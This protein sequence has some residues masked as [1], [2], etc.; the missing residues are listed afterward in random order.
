MSSPEKHTIAQSEDPI[1]AQFMTKEMFKAIR[2]QETVDI[3]RLPMPINF[4]PL[5]GFT[6]DM[7]EALKSYADGVRPKQFRSMLKRKAKKACKVTAEKLT[8]TFE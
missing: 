6:K 4:E 8:I 5:N 7:N 2:P 3:S 1:N